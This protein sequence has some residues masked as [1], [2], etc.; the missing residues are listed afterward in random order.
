[1]LLSVSPL[2]GTLRIDAHTNG[3]AAEWMAVA[4]V[5]LR[6]YSASNILC[7]PRHNPSPT[8]LYRPVTTEISG[9]DYCLVTDLDYA[10]TTDG[11]QMRAERTGDTEQV[12][13]TRLFPA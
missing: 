11:P 12:V 7:R 2:P 10:S 13:S 9:S 8:V 1:M 3:L 5:M 6:D 4:D